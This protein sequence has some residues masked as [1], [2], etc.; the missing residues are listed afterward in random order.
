MKVGEELPRQRAP[1]CQPWPLKPLQLNN[2]FRQ[3]T[4]CVVQVFTPI[5]N[6]LASVFGHTVAYAAH[7][8]SYVDTWVSAVP[9]TKLQ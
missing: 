4:S 9:I 5:N 2:H 1:H 7:I 8:P 3:Q 6:T